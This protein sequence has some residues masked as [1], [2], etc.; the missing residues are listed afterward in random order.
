MQE[1]RWLLLEDIDAAPMDLLSL[2]LPVINR[3]SL[4]LSGRKKKLIAHPN[5]QVFTTQRLVYI[6]GLNRDIGIYLKFYLM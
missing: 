1:G 5:F 3:R 2:I 6:V 4:T